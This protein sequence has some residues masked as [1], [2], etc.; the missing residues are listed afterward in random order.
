M[1]YK[2]DYVKITIENNE[3]LK[4]V[5][6]AIRKYKSNANT[7]KYSTYNIDG[8]DYCNVKVT[9]YDGEHDTHEFQT[10]IPLG[11]ATHHIKNIVFKDIAYNNMLIDC[12]LSSEYGLECHSHNLS[13]IK[14][15]HKEADYWLDTI[16]VKIKNKTLKYDMICSEYT[17][18]LKF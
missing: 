4:K 6:R 3:F 12:L 9:I 5:R 16:I 17:S 1:D 8:T 15:N 11:L 7:F 10:S 13:N 14:I 2:S 18:A